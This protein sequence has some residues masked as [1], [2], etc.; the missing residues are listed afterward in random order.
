MRHW[1]EEDPWVDG[2][3]DRIV[4]P[5]TVTGGRTRSDH[6]DVEL[7]AL[8]T[9]VRPPTRAQRLQPVQHALL[10]LCRRPMALVEVAARLDLPVAV[11]RVLLGDLLDN[12]LISVS[13]PSAAG[14]PDARFLQA[15]I[16]GIRRL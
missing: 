2:D 13:S 6:A 8:I 5:Y 4:R 7:I 15:V 10:G 12:E 11:I 16:D 1:S 9:T 14:A 3:P